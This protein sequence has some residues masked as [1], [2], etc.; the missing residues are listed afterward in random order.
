LKDTLTLFLMFATIVDTR[1]C[2]VEIGDVVIDIT[3][4]VRY[5]RNDMKL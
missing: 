4:D 1:P 3:R 2:A 5:R